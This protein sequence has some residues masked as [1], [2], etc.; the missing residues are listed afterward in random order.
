MSRCL[1]SPAVLQRTVLAA[2]GAAEIC[3]S[4]HGDELDRRAWG[5]QMVWG[6]EVLMLPSLRGKGGRMGRS[7]PMELSNL[8][9]RVPG[10]RGMLAQLLKGHSVWLKRWSMRRAEGTRGR[11]AGQD[12]LT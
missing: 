3:L 7:D 1:H 9:I 8:L 5:W 11:A 6:L 2:L 12:R 4:S 10:V